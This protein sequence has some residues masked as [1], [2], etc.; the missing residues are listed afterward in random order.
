MSNDSIDSKVLKRY[1][2]GTKLGEG[3]YGIVWK[4][5]DKKTKEVVALKKIFGA[6]NNAT[7][8]QRTFRE[9]QFLQELSDHINIVR[10]L[11]V[12]KA[13]NDVDIYLVFEFMETDL[14]AVIRADILEGIHKQYVL[15]QLLKSLKYIHS[16]AVIHRDLKPSN[17]LLNSDCL[18][19]VADFGLA[20]SITQEIEDE[21]VV[22]TE[23]VAT[24]WYRAPEILLGSTKYT[25]GVD[26][27]AV[28]CILGELLG[29]RPIFPGGSTLDQLER[30]CQV[31]G[32]PTASDLE[33][34]QSQ[35]ASTLLEHL[36][37]PPA[38]R[39]LRE[40]Y[41]K[42]PAEALDLMEKMLYFN[43][44]KRIT[45]SD[46]LAHPYLSQFHN[47]ADETEASEPV[48]I[49][50][51][52]NIKLP[53]AEYRTL[54]YNEIKKKRKEKNARIKAK[55]AEAK[56]KKKE[57][58]DKKKKKKTESSSSSKS[59]E[60]ADKKKKKE[61]SEK[62]DAAAVDKK[63]KKSKDSKDSDKKKKST[64]TKAK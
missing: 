26:M 13:D 51:D 60:S 38:P 31:T 34:I 11:K 62:K 49:P 41:P 35:Y 22:M 54:L 10:L 19:K 40:I 15:Y 20:R 3:A 33:A 18:V 32:K 30:I 57:E 14:H 56:L 45:A 55:K 43:P 46:A 21:Q 5:T 52:D 48:F 50:V 53:L 16:A 25:K 59:K 27:W 1:D 12:M 23:Y 61:S 58:K 37:Y 47:P 24:R 6:F 9:I 63:K 4:A 7:D 17:I 44:E 36:K 42:A 64:T 2:I 29:G 39:T 8:A 28:G